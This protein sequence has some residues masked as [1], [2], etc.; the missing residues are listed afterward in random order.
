MSWIVVVKR[1]PS[2][3]LLI[4]RKRSW[5]PKAKMNLP[6]LGSVVEVG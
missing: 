2:Q 1:E 3:K 5:I 4:D 6:R